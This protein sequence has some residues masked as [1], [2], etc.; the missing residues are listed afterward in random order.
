MEYGHW[1]AV[2]RAAWRM[3]GLWVCVGPSADGFLTDSTVAP[4]GL[5][6]FLFKG[7]VV[8]LVHARARGLSPRYAYGRIPRVLRRGVPVF[9]DRL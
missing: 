1:R 6:Q 7:G 8:A 2:R 4:L 3:D 5:A 9:L